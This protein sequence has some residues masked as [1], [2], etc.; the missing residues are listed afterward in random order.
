MTF[1]LD[2]DESALARHL[3]EG[4]AETSMPVDRPVWVMLLDGLDGGLEVAVRDDGF[5]PLGWLAPP[6][7]QVFAMVGTGRV[8]PLDD[9][10]ELPASLAG[11]RAGGVRMACVVSRRGRVGWHMVLPDGSSFDHIPEE[12]R[13]LDLL[14]RTLGL[15]TAP[16]PPTLGRLQCAAW[17]AAVIDH[18]ALGQPMSWSAVLDLHPALAGRDAGPDT[19]TKEYALGL[20]LRELTWEDVRAAVAGGSATA[21]SAVA[22]LP[23]P[24]LAAWMDAGMFA[25]WVLAGTP[26]LDALLAR[27]RPYLRPP[28]ARRLTHMVRTSA[29]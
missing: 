19:A 16:P 11:G 22:G 20:H 4:A 14:K 6:E 3:V 1:A 8:R 29:A 26:D 9:A 17:L 25:R 15:P 10:V 2:C 28:A 18:A 24:E 13:V 27:A 21:G 7:C 5:D 23:H 12:G